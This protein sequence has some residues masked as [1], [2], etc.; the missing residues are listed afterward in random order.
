MIRNLKTAALAA[1]SLSLGVSLFAACSNNHHATTQQDIKHVFVIVLENK[2]Y[3]DT[4]ETSTQDPYLRNTLRPQGALLTQYFGTGH[5]SL[6]NYIAMISGQ[7]SSKSTE[8]DCTTYSDFTMSGTTEDGQAIGDGCVYPASI[9]TLPDQMTAAGLSWKGYM[10]DMG[11]DPTRES[12]T[13]GH[14]E[15]GSADLTNTPE[16]A[17][18]SVPAGDQYA[19]RHDPFVYFHSIIDSP[20]CDANVVNLDQLDTDLASAD[21]TPNFVFITPNVCNDGHDGDG[22][23]AAGKGC[24]GGAPGGLSSADAF[25]QTWVPKIMASD[26]YKQNGL[27]IITFDESS[28]ASTDVSTDADTGKTT[29]TLTFDGASCCNQQIGP[30]ITRPS[31]ET[32]EASSSLTYVL[33][34]VGVGG[35]RIG[36]LL[37]SPYIK[38]DTTSDVPYNHYAML[39]SVE[40]IFGLAHLGYADQADLTPFGSDIFNNF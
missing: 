13:C 18:E 38:A 9:K 25:L 5:V 14:P 26:A 28:Y 21:T 11:N 30:N 19:T 7:A 1:L 12:A 27:L 23:G 8:S 4:W 31:E 35:D 10:Q 36:A 34:T 15:I 32:F 39:R 33:K 16:A 29:Y 22:T 2:N 24:V 17:S 37:L 20:T 6:D 3:Q 40:D